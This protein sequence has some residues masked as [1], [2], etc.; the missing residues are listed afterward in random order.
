MKQIQVV[1]ERISVELGT[2]GLQ[3][4]RPNQSA[5]PPP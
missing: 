2:S 1:R 5:T 4:Q 3:V